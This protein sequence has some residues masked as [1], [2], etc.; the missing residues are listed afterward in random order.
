MKDTTVYA[1]VGCLEKNREALILGN[2]ALI[3]TGRSS[4]KASGALDTVTAILDGADI[5]YTVFDEITENPLFEDCRRAGERGHDFGCDFV[6][7]IGG[8]SPLDAAKAA[9]AFALHPTMS[10]EQLYD[11]ASYPLVL[12]IVAVPLTAGTGSEVNA[13][14]VLTCGDRK[15]SFCTPDTLPRVAFLEPRFLRTLS[16]RYTVSTM[17]DAFS[18]CLESYLSPKSTVESEKDALA[19]G[20]LL[21]EL[22]TQND[23]ADNGEDRAGLTEEQRLSSLLGASY[24]GRAIKVTGTGFPHPLG[25]GLTLRHGIPHGFACGAFAGVY[26]EKNQTTPLGRQRLDAFADAIG[27]TPAIIGAVIPALSDV[28]LSLTAEE[29]ETMIALVSGAKNYVN[30]PYLLSDEE[31]KAI[32]TD[33]FGV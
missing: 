28:N 15:R 13:Y 25:Y 31:G 9:A 5:P 6:I 8:G 12:P 4:A 19:G 7:G 20:K 18:H 24:G 21:W 3:V 1:G 23:F 2:R 32:L 11:T 33:F 10:E 27:T 22:L 29:I 17:I 26:I 16:A 14:A 30:A